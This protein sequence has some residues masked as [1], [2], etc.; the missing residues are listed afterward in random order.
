MRE[1]SVYFLEKESIVVIIEAKALKNNK[2]ET[3]FD[4]NHFT[5]PSQNGDHKRV[6]QMKR[7]K[8]LRIESDSI[9]TH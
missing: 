8:L 2:K 6:I 3:C 5:I 7:K 4:K 1:F 9:N